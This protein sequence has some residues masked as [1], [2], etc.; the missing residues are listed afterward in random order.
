VT[1]ALS[2]LDNPLIKKGLTAQFA[3]RRARPAAG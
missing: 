1:F 2:D 3:T